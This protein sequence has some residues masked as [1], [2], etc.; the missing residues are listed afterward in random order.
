MPEENDAS[1]YLELVQDFAR[2]VVLVACVG[3]AGFVCAVVY[4]A[5]KGL[6]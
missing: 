4:S 1:P 2:A 3:L 6:L 5:L